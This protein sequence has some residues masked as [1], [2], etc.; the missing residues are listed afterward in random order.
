MIDNFDYKR[1]EHEEGLTKFK[2]SENLTLFVNRNSINIVKDT[3]TLK[4]TIL[5]IQKIDGES[6]KVFDWWGWGD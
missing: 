6:L 4:V 3:G 5:S 2:L 1:E